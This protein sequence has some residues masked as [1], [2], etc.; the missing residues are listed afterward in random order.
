MPRHKNPIHTPVREEVLGVDVGIKQAWATSD[1]QTANHDGP[2]GC[3]CPRVPRRPGGRRGRFQHRQGCSY[4]RPKALQERAIAKPGGSTRLQRRVSK[5]RLKLERQ[6]PPVRMVAIEG[7]RRRDMMASARGGENAPGQG[8]KG[9]AGLNRALAEAA[10]GSTVAILH[11]EA[12]KRG[13]PVVAVDPAYSSRTCARCGHESKESRKSQ[14]VFECVA[15]GWSAN[16]DHNASGVIAIRAYR[17]QVDPAALL[18]APFNRRVDYSS[19]QEDGS[20]SPLAKAHDATPVAAARGESQ[21]AERRG[22]G[23]GAPRPPRR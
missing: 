16:A 10:S 17:Q 5:R 2:H 13:V 11:R 12:A 4:G 1:G 20:D 21:G 7:L 19:G 6:E 18:G 3:Y 8:V 22:G 23:R 9:K 15:C 14:A